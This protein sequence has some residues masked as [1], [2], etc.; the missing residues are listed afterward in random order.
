M[1]PLDVVTGR[2]RMLS[3]SGGVTNLSESFEVLSLSI[4]Y[5]SFSFADVKS[6]TIPATGFV[7]NLRFLRPVKPIFI[8][9]ERLN[10]ASVLKNNLEVH[11]TIKLID[12]R[13]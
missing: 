7:D 2:N 10:S 11:E 3:N 4:M 5:S 13:F 8:R 1:V 6:I 12:A 9:K